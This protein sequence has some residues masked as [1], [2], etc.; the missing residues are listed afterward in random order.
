MDAN[1]LLSAFYI[2]FFGDFSVVGK[3]VGR[4][5]GMRHELHNRKAMIMEQY[6]QEGG[7]ISG[8]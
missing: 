2:L 1:C 6:T 5:A 3:V 8:L 7:N 4:Y